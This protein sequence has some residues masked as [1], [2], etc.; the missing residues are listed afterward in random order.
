M[1]TRN[2]H[3]N[4]QI[5][6]PLSLEEAYAKAAAYCAKAERSERAVRDKFYAWRVE[7]A[8]Y[9]AVIDRLRGNRYID[10]ARFALSF[11]RDKHRF[12]AWGRERIRHELSLHRISSDII[13]STLD[14]VF[15]E[16]DEEEQLRAVLAKKQRQLK[17]SD[18]PRKHFEQMMRY[19]IYRGYA[20]DQAKRTIERLLRYDA[21]E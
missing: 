8:D 2:A 13:A 9:D 10:D 4:P 19:A 18:P 16:F 1:K 6:K 17:A 20:Y 14:E 11:A 21:D 15:D 5:R 3:A 7:R 12:S